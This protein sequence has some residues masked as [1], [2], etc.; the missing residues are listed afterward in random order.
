MHFDLKTTS[1]AVTDLEVALLIIFA[2]STYFHPLPRR[3]VPLTATRDSSLSW[4]PMRLG[5]WGSAQAPP[6]DQGGARPPKRLVILWPENEVREAPTPSQQVRAS[7]DGG[8]PPNMHFYL[9]TKSL[10]MTDIEVTHLI[11][12]R[13]FHLLPSPTFSP[14]RTPN[15]HTRVFPS[16][17]PTKVWRPGEA[18]KLPQRVRAEPGRQTIFGTF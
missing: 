1:L 15:L 12:I 2:P 5:H 10:A 6:A 14:Q 8:R 4:N 9:K 7:P 16:M 17:A 18:F 13:P 11:Y 3:K